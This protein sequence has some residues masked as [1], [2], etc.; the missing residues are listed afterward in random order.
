[1]SNAKSESKIIYILI[2]NNGDGS[3]INKFVEDK[4]V[5]D[6]LHHAYL[7][8]MIGVEMPGVDGDGFSSTEIYVPRNWS[9]ND[10]GV[11]FYTLED[12]KYDLEDSE[13]SNSLMEIYNRIVN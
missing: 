8:S 12:L 11:S 7:D 2:K 3:G 1:M 5:I 9:E 4:R 6:V 10:L 13:N